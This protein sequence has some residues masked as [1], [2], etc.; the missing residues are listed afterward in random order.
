LTRSIHGNTG[1]V[2]H[3]VN[4]GP[5]GEP[6]NRAT[7]ASRTAVSYVCG[8]G[9]TT[10]PS[11]FAD[12]EAPQHWVCARCSRP[13]SRDG[14]Q[15]P[16]DPPGFRAEQR[17]HLDHVKQRRPSQADRDRLLDE[18]LAQLHARRAAAQK[19]AGPGRLLGSGHGQVVTH[20][21]VLGPVALAVLPPPPVS[22]IA[23][24]GLPVGRITSAGT[25]TIRRQP[26][27][28]SRAAR[29][30]LGGRPPKVSARP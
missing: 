22:A 8:D 27:R 4:A 11:F 21:E 7:F 10:S 24:V 29:H 25:I 9:H 16:P 3:R 5:A 18:A 30:A 6:D 19:A 26:R 12:A 17:S 15:I 23:I 14:E 1:V 2:G 28:R 20:A 13:A